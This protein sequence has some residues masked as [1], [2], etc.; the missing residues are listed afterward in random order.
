VQQLT[1]DYAAAAVSHQ[2][3][4]EMSR[5]LGER[6]YQA[7]VL[8]SLGELST[9]TAA[10]QQA[11]DYHTQALAIARALGVPLEQ[12]RALEGI[13]RSHLQDGHAGEGAAKLRQA[14]AIYQRIGAPDAQR[15]Q[16]TLRSRS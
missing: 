5:D 16:E 13:G 7:E 14:L 10:S 2:Q 3:A 8:N 15:V 12:A 1:G 6:Y 9:R 4:L 11:R